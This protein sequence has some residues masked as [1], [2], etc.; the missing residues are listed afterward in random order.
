M[1]FDYNAMT[2]EELTG[3][4]HS[5]AAGTDEVENPPKKR[6]KRPRS[7]PAEAMPRDSIF[8]EHF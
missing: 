1:K 4:V 6:P 2:D 3:L 5:L 8:T 7:S